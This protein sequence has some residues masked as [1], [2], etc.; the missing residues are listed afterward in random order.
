MVSTEIQRKSRDT[1]IPTMDTGGTEQP[2][3]PQCVL[4]AGGASTVCGKCRT[5]RYCSRECQ[6]SDWKAHKKKCPT[7]AEENDG[8]RKPLAVQVQ[9]SRVIELPTQQDIRKGTEVYWCFPELYT[10]EKYKP[11]RS[12]LTPTLPLC[13]ACTD[14]ARLVCETCKTTSYC[15]R[16]CQIDDWEK[17]EKE[18]D[19]LSAREPTEAQKRLYR[20]VLLYTSPT[21]PVEQP[22]PEPEPEPEPGETEPVPPYVGAQQPAFGMNY[23]DTCGMCA[24]EA[25][26]RCAGCHGPKYCSWQCGEKHWSGGHHTVCDDIKREKEE[27][28]RSE[29]EYTKDMS[30]EERMRYQMDSY[31][32]MSSSFARLAP[33]MMEHGFWSTP[34]RW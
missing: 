4:C 18:C 31:S 29:Y 13:A 20:A 5:T 8:Q 21:P 30:M 7:M 6:V 9:G 14:S 34:S 2:E 26:Y 10:P 32:R 16:Y 27:Q 12:L 23:G 22:A 24:E 17:H 33:M 3:L 19:A 25:F 15:S 1:C 11:N 28:R